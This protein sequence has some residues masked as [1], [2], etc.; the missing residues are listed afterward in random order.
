MPAE[1]IEIRHHDADEADHRSDRQVDAAAKNDEGRADGGDDDEGVV[2]EDVAEHERRQEIVVEQPA[3][4]EQR[5]EDGDG[6]EQRQ[7]LLAHR[8]LPAKPL[9][10]ARA[11]IVRLQQEDDDDDERLDDQ[12]VLRRQA[13]GENR[14]RQRLNDQRAQN[15]HAKID[16]PARQRAAADD[17]GENGVELDVEADADGIGRMGVGGQH[18]ARPGRA[19]SAD[20]I[21]RVLDQARVDPGQIRRRRIAAD[22]FEKQSERGAADQQPQ[23]RRRSQRPE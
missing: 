2:G 21:G 15:R 3:G 20:E 5:R 9:D 19:Q 13:A 1:R 8:F 16:A 18:H 14:G 4:D 6:G 23:A 22:R 7:V 10:R 11:K 17:D 12:I